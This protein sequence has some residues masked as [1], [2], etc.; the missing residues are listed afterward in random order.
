[1]WDLTIETVVIAVLASFGLS[2][3]KLRAV[4]HS[5]FDSMT[6]CTRELERRKVA[7]P[8]VG[9]FCMPNYQTRVLAGGVPLFGV[10]LRA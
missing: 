6:E 8:D 3:G 7:E 10:A 9:F 2:E 5:T 1:M 4:T